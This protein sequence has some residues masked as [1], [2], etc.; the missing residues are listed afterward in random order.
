MNWFEADDYCS[1]LTPGAGL[2]EITNNF[3]QMLL[4]GAI[5]NFKYHFDK[6]WIGG[7]TDNIENI[8]VNFYSKQYT[9]LYVYVKLWQNVHLIFNRIGLL[10][11]TDLELVLNQEKVILLILIQHGLKESGEIMM[12]F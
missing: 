8:A 2:A 1:H 10:V 3:T 11:G 5:L 4:S 12:P 6:F 7:Y 9:K